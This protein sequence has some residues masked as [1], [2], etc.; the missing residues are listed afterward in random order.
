MRLCA[1]VMCVSALCSLQYVDYL[2]LIAL[3]APV[4]NA[5]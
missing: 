1:L 4:D 5:W 2:S 3:F